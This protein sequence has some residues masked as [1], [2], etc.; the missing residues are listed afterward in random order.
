[1]WSGTCAIVALALLYATSRV[2]VVRW[3]SASGRCIGFGE[4]CVF[5][6]WTADPAEAE[7]RQA[8]AYFPL[9]WNSW[10]LTPHDRNRSSPAPLLIK[11]LDARY[12]LGASVPIWM[13]ISVVTVPT[14]WFRFRDRRSR[15]GLCPNCGY[16][17]TGLPPNSPCP[18]CGAVP[19]KA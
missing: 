4:G 17:L 5:L 10:R 2:W 3:W 14:L 6:R 9:G 8:G 15:P 1:M 19:S 16:S 11:S 7:F 18:E 12:T 13:L